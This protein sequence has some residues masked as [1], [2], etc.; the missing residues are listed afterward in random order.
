MESLMELPSCPR[1]G[2][3]LNEHIAL[4]GKPAAM[5]PGDISLCAYCVCPLMYDGE[6][7][8]ELT[9][10]ALLLARLNWHFARAEGVL[11]KHLRQKWKQA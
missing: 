2:E 8:T 4:D 10:D 7:L 9:D 6:R 5:K 1:C 11:R 3:K